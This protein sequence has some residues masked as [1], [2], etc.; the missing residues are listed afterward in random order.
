MPTRT[1]AHPNQTLKTQLVK[2]DLS[3]LPFYNAPHPVI[4]WQPYCCRFEIICCK[5]AR[6]FSSVST[7]SCCCARN[8]SS[9]SWAITSDRFCWPND[10]FCPICLVRSRR[11][12]SF[13]DGI[14]IP[15]LVS[16]ELARL[17]YY[18]ICYL[19]RRKKWQ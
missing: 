19:T 1:S 3:L 7:A 4:Y 8:N 5:R 15:L 16:L 2:S 13:F 12:V 17:L 6:V 14:K 18:I 11:S 9:R 10:G